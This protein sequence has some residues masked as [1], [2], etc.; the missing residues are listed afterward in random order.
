MSKSTDKCLLFFKILQSALRFTWDDHCQQAFKDL[1]EYQIVLLLLVSLETSET[2]YLYLAAYEE[3]MATILILET[4]KGQ[5][6]MYY[7]NKALHSSELN[8]KK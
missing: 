2:L 7:V 6:S 1:K 4:P 3:T 5:F 8:Y